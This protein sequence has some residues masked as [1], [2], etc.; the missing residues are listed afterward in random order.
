MEGTGRGTLFPW[1]LAAQTF[2][3]YQAIERNVDIE[4]VVR[5]YALQ[6]AVMYG[7]KAT[8]GAVLGKVMAENPE[9]RAEAKDVASTARTLIEEVNSL[10][11]DE[12]RKALFDVARDSGTWV[13]SDEV[14]IGSEHDGTVTESL[15]GSYERTLVTNGLC[16]SY[17]L[18]GL[19]IG[20]LVGEPEALE[21]IAEYRDYLTLTH[22]APSDYVA[23][24]VLEPERRAKILSQNQA[25]IR[26]GHG[27]FR[28]WVVDRDALFTYTPPKAGPMCFVKYSSIIESLDLAKRLQGESS[29]LVV[30]GS[31]LG[32]EGYLRIATGVPRAYLH[33][34]LDRIRDLMARL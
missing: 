28:D 32:M 13:F 27:N 1:G 22:S 9:L 7:G 17:G 26:D 6:N 21:E 31:Q 29:V 3:R 10:S 12:Q 16:K 23:R 25:T 34:G 20:W 33:A 19:R 2:Y 18:P 15:W 30:P 11:E 24:V 4:S 5:K 14:Y 8:L